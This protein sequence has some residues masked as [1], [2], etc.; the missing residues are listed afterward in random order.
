MVSMVSMGV[1]GV[2]G[3]TSRWGRVKVTG[4]MRNTRLDSL[5]MEAAMTWELTT[6]GGARGPP[7]PP[8]RTDAFSVGRNS[9]RLL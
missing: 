7:S 3:P 9:P 2:P 8:R 5:L 6:K 1:S 4:S